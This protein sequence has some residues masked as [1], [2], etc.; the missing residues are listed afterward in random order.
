[1]LVLGW[2]SAGFVL[3]YLVTKRRIALGIC[4][5]L[6]LSAATFLFLRPERPYE[7]GPDSVGVLVMMAF[8]P[9]GCL[10]GAFL[11]ARRLDGSEGGTG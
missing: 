2:L 5:V 6:C 8:A 4:V 1:M 3:G 7:L 10:L 11:R 9:V